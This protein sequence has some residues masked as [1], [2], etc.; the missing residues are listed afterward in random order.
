MNPVF[1]IFNF[2]A[3]RRF[4]FYKN[5]IIFKV[6]SEIVFFLWCVMC[7]LLYSHNLYGWKVRNIFAIM[8]PVCLNFH[9]IRTTYKRKRYTAAFVVICLQTI[10]SLGLAVKIQD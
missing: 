9:F 4:Q 5:I 10:K 3:L 1:L 7:I 8:N 6:I 2:L